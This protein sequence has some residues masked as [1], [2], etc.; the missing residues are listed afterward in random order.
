MNGDKRQWITVAMVFFLFG[1][2]GGESSSSP[3]PRAD[4]TEV[5]S[6]QDAS[7]FDYDPQLPLDIEE[8]Y[9]EDVT[10]A[11]IHHVSYAS[12]KGGRVD[13]LLVVP[14]GEG[15]FAGVVF[16]HAGG[17]TMYEFRGE[18][19]QL[20]PLGFESISV[21]AGSLSSD[22]SYIRLVINLRRAIDLLLT[23]SEVDPR[24]IGYIG[25]SVGAVW[26]GVLA[27]VEKRVQAYVLMGG[28]P[29]I[30]KCAPC[31]VPVPE[32]LWA[33]N[34]IGHAAPAAVYFQFALHD[35]YI[36]IAAANLYYQLASEPKFID[37]YDAYHPLN[38]EAQ[39]DRIN[40][41]RERLA[42]VPVAHTP[43]PPRRHLR[44]P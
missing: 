34:Y 29:E 9:V 30:G 16:L 41:L 21:N 5:V 3:P 38:E 24:R 10:D 33:S 36:S 14:K 31:R 32:Y 8:T 18:A 23:R 35:E 25:H 40:W 12:P 4:A 39:I 26:G 7:T 15:P 44:R 13:A 1:W 42:S 19:L 28:H 43:R 27:G 22:D 2:F 6:A 11:A 37:W 17:E 20:A